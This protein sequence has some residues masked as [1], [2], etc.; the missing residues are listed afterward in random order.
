MDSQ[1]AA[2]AAHWLHACLHAQSGHNSAQ[3]GGAKHA[4]LVLDSEWSNYTFSFSQMGDT[5]K[6]QLGESLNN[7]ARNVC[8]HAFQKVTVFPDRASAANKADAILHPKVAKMDHAI[9]TLAWQDRTFILL[10]EWTM[11]DGADQKTL[12]LHTAE[13]QAAHN[14]GNMLTWKSNEKK[15]F[16]KLFDNLTANTVAPLKAASH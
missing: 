11:R 13:G 16:Q 3:P 2:G 5:W 8:Q 1:P 12:W 7:Y 4:A 15:V 14:A 6:Y 10:V 9:G